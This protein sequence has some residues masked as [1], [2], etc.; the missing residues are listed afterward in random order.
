M[1]ISS[2]KVKTLQTSF[3]WQVSWF[4]SLTNTFKWKTQKKLL[5]ESLVMCIICFIP[6]SQE[7]WVWRYFK[8]LS[9][10]DLTIWK[11]N[12]H[13]LNYFIRICIIICMHITSVFI[14]IIRRW[15]HFLQK[16]HHMSILYVYILV[17]N[18]IW[19]NSAHNH[20]KMTSKCPPY[21]S[22]LPHLSEI[23]HTSFNRSRKIVISF[24]K[25]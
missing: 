20:T 11:N 15:Q 18:Y 6:I 9:T 12:V 19:N 17:W 21:T 1:L 14:Y 7:N 2:I 4:H 5:E 24:I 13:L 23:I 16:S 3:P 22:T 25:L 10:P 8:Q